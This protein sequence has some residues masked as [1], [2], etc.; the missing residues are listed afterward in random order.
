MTRAQR[1]LWSDPTVYVIIVL[2]Y[3]S[4]WFAYVGAT[5]G[6]YGMALLLGVVNQAPLA[7]VAC[8]HRMRMSEDVRLTRIY[9]EE[10]VR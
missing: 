8:I 1:M 9:I 5:K 3:V 2:S 6:M 4:V 10:G 7:V